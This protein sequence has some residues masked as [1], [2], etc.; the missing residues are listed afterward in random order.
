MNDDECRPVYL[1]LAVNNT[2]KTD[3]LQ[4]SEE[5]E[6]FMAAPVGINKLNSLM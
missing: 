3:S 2:S 4:S 1:Y 6:W 5:R